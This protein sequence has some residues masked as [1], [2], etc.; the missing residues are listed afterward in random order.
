MY[1]TD[2]VDASELSD[3]ESLADPKWKG[4]I[5]IRS[6]SNIYNQSLVASMI[7]ANGEEATEAWARGLVANLG[8][9]PT[10]GD[11]DQIKAAA[12]GVCDVAVANT[13]YFGK[14]EKSSDSVQRESA[15]KMKVFWPNRS[16]RGTHVNVSGI[17]VTSAASHRDEAIRLIEFLLTDEAQSWYAN[18]NYEYPV[19]EGVAWG[20]T[21]T[22]WGVFKADQIDM[23]ELGR[24]NAAAVRLM[25][26]A[27]WR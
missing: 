1:V 16:G 4:R 6:S 10:G 20:E 26:R 3:Y 23:A 18:V 24:N 15:A 8:K 17:G 11:R 14:M 25:D 22:A 19:K 12:V 2:K 7:A 27:G 21:V 9:S 13:Y 5:C